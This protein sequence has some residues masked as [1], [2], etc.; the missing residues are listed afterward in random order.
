M[1]DVA[2]SRVAGGADH[3]IILNAKGDTIY[4]CG[5]GGYGQLGIPKSE[6]QTSD[7][8]KQIASS[9][10]ERY[11]LIPRRVAF[12]KT[13]RLAKIGRFVDVFCGDNHSGAIT[14]GG[15]IYTWGYGEYGQCGNDPRVH[16]DD[17]ERPRLNEDWIS[18]DQG[19]CV[20]HGAGG[21]QHTL[22]VASRYKKS[23]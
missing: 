7:E 12:P 23:A 20:H 1:K 13:D 14:S 22:I 9:K 6:L 5:K 3:S 16:T 15:K 17:F 21:S 8:N 18:K 2:I 4:A 19:L 10:K 11:S